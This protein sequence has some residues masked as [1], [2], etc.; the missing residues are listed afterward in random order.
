MGAPEPRAEGVKVGHE[1]VV[2]QVLSQGRLDV[3][4]AQL[5]EG[6][7]RRLVVQQL[8]ELG[9]GLLVAAPIR[10][11]GVLEGV[12]DVRLAHGRRVEFSHGIERGLQ[13]GPVL[14]RRPFV[15]QGDH[16]AEGARR[17]QKRRR[18]LSVALAL[19][20]DRVEAYARDSQPLRVLRRG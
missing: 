1:V 3:G 4:R 13:M 8:L 19:L 10:R 18:L 17:E 6:G 2:E 11:M 5:L 15:D 20:H 12:G 16:L 9:Q 14:R 7:A